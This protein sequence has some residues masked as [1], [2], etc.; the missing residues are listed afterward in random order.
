VVHDVSELV[1]CSC[2]AGLSE[3]LSRDGDIVV[4]ATGIPFAH[5]AAPP[6]AL[7]ARRPEIVGTAKPEGYY[8]GA[9]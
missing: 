1:E 5:A 9:R 2:R 7:C 6:V 3:D 4:I 8:S